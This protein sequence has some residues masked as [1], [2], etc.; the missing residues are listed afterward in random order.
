VK[1]SKPAIR[2]TLTLNGP[3]S[4]RNVEIADYLKAEGAPLNKSDFSDWTTC[5]VVVVNKKR[6]RSSVD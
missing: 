1:G 4:V 5:A 2:S 6:T 3:A